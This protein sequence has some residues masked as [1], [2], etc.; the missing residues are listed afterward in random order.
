M[1]GDTPFDVEGARE[2]GIPTIGVTWG[3][4]ADRLSA[5]N[6][7][8]MIDRAEDLPAAV[9]RLCSVLNPSG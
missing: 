3:H 1:I 2:H 7:A 4:G 9:G 8:V 5:S 6:P